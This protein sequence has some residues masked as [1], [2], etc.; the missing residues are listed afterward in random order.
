MG[1]VCCVGFGVFVLLV[2]CDAARVEKH[3]KGRFA[4]KT[5]AMVAFDSPL[6][7]KHKQQDS[8]AVS[9]VC[10]ESTIQVQV[11]RDLFGTGQLIQPSD[12][13][14]GDCAVTRQDDVAQVLFFEE[15]LQDCLSN[16]SMVAD[17]LVYSF[18]LDYSPSMLSGTSIVRTDTAAYDIECH[19]PRFHN[20]S[21]N[22]LDPT[23]VPYTSTKSAEDVL[24][25]SLTLMTDDWRS[26]RPSNVYFLGDVLNL[27]ASFTVADHMPLLLFVDSCVAT[28]DSDPTSSPSYTF[29][30]NHGCLTDAKVTGSSSRFMPRPQ[31]NTTLQMMLDAFRFSP[32]ASSSIYISC[33]LKVI[34]A[35]QNVD[36]V[37]KA[38]YTE[39][40]SWISV[41]GSDQVCGCCDSSCVPGARS[42]YFR[43][44][45]RDLA[46]K[47]A[48]EWEG[49]ATVTV[50]V[51]EKNWDS[52]P[53]MGS[54]VQSLPSMGDEKIAGV[55]AEVVVLAGVVIAVGLV[56]IAV[57]GTVLY[58]RPSKSMS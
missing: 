3:G 34:P 36:S 44:Y 10:G 5:Q 42:R 45:R 28:L 48:E 11:K 35:S 55:P 14:L 49:D 43:R 31:D 1:V 6:Y 46:S 37:N 15:E 13:S 47:G 2:L 19:Y 33:H 9:A 20:V 41:D 57:L 22:A 29:I 32:N 27:Q 53:V 30:G 58:R 7:P 40:N 21:S 24:D 38:C 26:A 52:L 51:L 17:E 8:Q 18:S 50:V 12:I 56:C 54:E 39:G 25:F 4:M 16:L 23:W